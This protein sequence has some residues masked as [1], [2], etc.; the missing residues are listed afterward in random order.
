MFLLRAFFWLALVTAVVPYEAFDPANGVVR[1][2]VAALK[3][4][5]YA[6]SQPCTLKPEACRRAGELYR[7][8]EATV[9]AFV[10]SSVRAS[11]Y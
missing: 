8:G 4:D 1:V 3:S 9:G 11:V 6:W 7:L 10:S 2:D 5:L